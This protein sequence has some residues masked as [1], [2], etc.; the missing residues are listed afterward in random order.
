MAQ[1][2]SKAPPSKT[3][4]FLSRTGKGRS[5]NLDFQKIL[6]L[7]DF[8]IPLGLTRLVVPSG[9][10]S[11]WRTSAKNSV[12]LRLTVERYSSD[13]LS[14]AIRLV[15]ILNGDNSLFAL[16]ILSLKVKL[17]RYAH[18]LKG[19]NPKF[20]NRVYA[21]SRQLDPEDRDTV[22]RASRWKH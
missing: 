18:I 10:L 2:R 14:Y 20:S 3:K 12:R 8:G 15:C 6:N 5:K 22:R 16:C 7:S 21:F 19:I 4:A 1:R 17:Q 9:T 13:F 11:P